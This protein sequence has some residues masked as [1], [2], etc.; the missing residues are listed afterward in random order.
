MTMHC[1]EDRFSLAVVYLI[2]FIGLKFGSLLLRSRK[3][4][5]R[6]EKDEGIHDEAFAGF[7]VM[8]ADGVIRL[9]RGEV[10][11]K[12]WQVIEKLG[13]G[14]CGYVYKVKN[15]KTG[16]KAALKA[17]S[18]LILGG[19]VLKL[20]VQ[21][22]KRLAGRM[23]VAELLQSARKETY[24]YM[25]MTL[26]G[27]SLNTLL[28]RSGHTSVSTQVRVGIH[29]L[30]GI[31]QL[32]E[33]G[34]VHRDVKPANLLVGRRGREA[35]IVHLL[36]FGLAREYVI[37]NS[38][39]VKIRVPRTNTLFRGTARYCSVNAHMRGEQ[40]RPDDLW[41]MAYV[42]AEMRGVLP[43]DKLTNKNEIG[44]IKKNTLDSVL[45]SNSPKQLLDIATHLRSLNYYTRPDYFQIYKDLESV[46]EASGFR[47]IRQYL[48]TAITYQVFLT[49]QKC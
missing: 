33:V 15:I 32:H 48:K 42:L 11:G 28:P 24:S 35:R 4:L 18:N 43:W 8:S 49:I 5:R 12:R 17:E 21:V 19:S 9:K 13:E 7:K 34:Y 14:G 22:L 39:T 25:V 23:H 26:F 40:G 3:Q 10:I 20:E 29:I 6:L 30:Y 37:R 41:S 38:G 45:F 16:A 2:C 36:D 46:M 47:Y 44:Q 1:L 31:K 27:R